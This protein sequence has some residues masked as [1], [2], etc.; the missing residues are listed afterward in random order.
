M[1]IYLYTPK[2]IN[3]IREGG[4]ILAQILEQVSQQVKP[5]VSTKELDDLAEK[6]ILERGGQVAF[7]GYQPASCDKPFPTTMCTSV[8]DEVVHAPASSSR[9]LK[10]GDIIGLDIGMRYKGYYTDHAITVGVGKISKS[11]EKLIEVTKHALSLGIQQA[12]IGNTVYDI[13][14]A[15]QQYIEDNGFSVVRALVGHG[16][17]KQ[18]HEEPAIPNF[19]HKYSKKVYLKQ[20]MVI[21]IEP[22]IN[23]GD[24]EV[25]IATDG[26]TYKT[27]DNSLSAHFEHTIAIGKNG[28]IVLTE[29]RGGSFLAS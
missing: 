21:A 14:L 18:I 26:F 17:G 19:T 29:T 3:T 22:M 9:I 23:I 4:R 11:A 15:I 27:S 20:G 16:V 10:D 13:S 5:G 8:N 6:L 24:Y 12:K 28:G 7:N 2:E 25:E 1:S